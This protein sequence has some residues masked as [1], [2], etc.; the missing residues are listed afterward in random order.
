[1]LVKKT[2]KNQITLPKEIIK[3]FPQIEYFEAKVEDGKIILTP[4]KIVSAN[5]TLEKIREKIKSLGIT[6]EDVKEAV[7]WARKN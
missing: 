3:N 7:K 4:V 6:E 2:S 1:M 5:I